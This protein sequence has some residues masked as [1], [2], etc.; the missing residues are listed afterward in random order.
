MITHM[1]YTL[2]AKPASTSNAGVYIVERWCK[3]HVER[4]DWP[5]SLTDNDSL[6]PW[7]GY[8]M[9][10]AAGIRRQALKAVGSRR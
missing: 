10:G 5:A 3:G 4:R 6:S 1:H 2:Y 7:A 8:V 9:Y